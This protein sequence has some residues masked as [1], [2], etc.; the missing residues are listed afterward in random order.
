MTTDVVT[1]AFSYTGRHVARLLNQQGRAVRTLTNHPLP[2]PSPIEVAPLRFDEPEALKRAL[3][4]ADTLY[5]TYWVR[6]VHGSS[7]FDRAVAN[8]ATLVDAAAAAGVRRIV[9]V[10]IANVDD[11]AGLPYFDGKAACEETVRRSGVSYAIVRPTVLFGGRDV[12]I[13]NIAWI[14]RRF[15]VFAVAGDGRYGIQPV[16]V[17][18]HARLIVEAGAR[19]GDEIFDSAGPEAF[20]FEEL[21][22]EIARAIGRRARI[23]HAPP[24]IVMAASRMIGMLA[25]DVVLNREELDGLMRGL[26]LSKEPARGRIA[27]TEWL[28]SAGNDLGRSYANEITRHYAK[29]P[30]L[31]SRH[32]RYVRSG[33]TRTRTGR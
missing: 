1:G 8:T 2:E 24:S 28:R 11:G 19:T 21:V 18:D 13:S 14:L 15:P 22:R 9:H 7:S 30:G 4:G 31:V 32:G 23:F 20:T 29:P 16:H 6:F 5:N 25:R 26:M 3:D 17:D 33:G 12:F 10:S 27:F